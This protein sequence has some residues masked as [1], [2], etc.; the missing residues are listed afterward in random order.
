MENEINNECFKMNMLCL[1]QCLISGI[2]SYNR[3]KNDLKNYKDNES[4]LGR[5][6]TLAKSES[7]CMIL[8]SSI[9]S[10]INAGI[11]FS[12]MISSAGASLVSF[13]NSFNQYTGEALK[14]CENLSQSAIAN[15]ARMST[16]YNNCVNGLIFPAALIALS[17]PNTIKEYKKEQKKEGMI[18]Q[19]CYLDDLMTLINDLKRGKNDL[20]LN[21]IREF[22]SNVDLTK[23]KMQFNSKLLNKFVNYRN[24]VLKV[25]N[26]EAVKDEELNG[27]SDLVD[28]LSYS[29][30]EPGASET[31]FDDNP[32]L[33]NFILNY[34]NSTKKTR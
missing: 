33:P 29:D 17:I 25:E 18:D 27:F 32:Y 14:I 26:G 23:N 15:S 1:E 2:N 30:M 8:T 21:F 20:S 12:A 6:F 10:L 13:T 3:L 24:S 11:G 22:L 34:M 28:F 16:A 19:M 5:T 7:I 31:L 9:P 4:I